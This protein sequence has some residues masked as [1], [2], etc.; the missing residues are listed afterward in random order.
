MTNDSKNQ[1]KQ[2]VTFIH[3]EAQEK[4]NEIQIRVSTVYYATFQENCLILSS[5]FRPRMNLIKRRTIIST[6]LR[7]LWMPSSNKRLKIWRSNR[8]SP[9][10]DSQ[11][12]L[13]LR[14]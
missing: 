9:S 3:Q 7:R 8:R 5:I 11:L 14:R 12:R 4:V 1:I 10:P 6:L 13:V 2:M